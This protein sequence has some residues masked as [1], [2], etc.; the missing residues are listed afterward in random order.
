MTTTKELIDHLTENLV[1]FKLD[2]KVE[3]VVD[4]K[5]AKQ[6]IHN[7]SE[8]IVNDEKVEKFLFSIGVALDLLGLRVDNEDYSGFKNEAEFRE[9]TGK[10]VSKMHSKRHEQEMYSCP[11]HIDGD[12][13]FEMIYDITYAFDALVEVCILEEPVENP[14]K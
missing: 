7:Y 5:A 3:S 13:I 9:Y 8:V 6:V 12:L 11:S 10:K 14:W 2:G 1:T 4:F